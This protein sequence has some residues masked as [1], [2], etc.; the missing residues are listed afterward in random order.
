M[1][2]HAGLAGLLPI[3]GG[4]GAAEETAM[5][6]RYRQA[7]P[8]C[9]ALGVAPLAEFYEALARGAQPPMPW[10]A[11]LDGEKERSDGAL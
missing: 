1:R 5:P 6:Q 4:A 7:A 8:A 9:E 11:T 10:G 3:V 2:S